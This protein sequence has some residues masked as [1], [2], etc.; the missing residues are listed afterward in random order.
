MGEPAPRHAVLIFYANETSQAAAHSENY[1]K[2]LAVLR[3]AGGAQAE[4]A[5][6]S[7]VRDAERFPALVQRD[8]G[9][10]L[11]AAQRWKFDAA[12][13]TNEMAFAG[14]YLLY[15]AATDKIEQVSLPEIPPT[16]SVILATSP[17]ARPD[18][19]RSA[20]TAVAAQY[21]RNSLDAVLITDTHGSG[22]M[23]LIPRVNADLS[24]PDAERQMQ[25]LLE[26]D[27][28]GVPP[29]WAE[30]PGT[31]KLAY[32]QTISDV[33]A[34]YG[35]R[36]PLAFREACDSGLRTWREFAMLPD[37]VGSVAHSAMGVLDSA[38]ISYARIF[39]DF[40]PGGDWQSVL[41]A[42][43]RGDG[44][45]VNGR[46]TI[47]LWVALIGL[48]SVPPILFFVPLGAWLIWYLAGVAV[49]RRRAVLAS[50]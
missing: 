37:S 30:L 23:A 9:D 4:Q 50:R 8:I 41:A 6:A 5:S 3:R 44:V 48:G 13:F 35:V 42:G 18:V 11:A 17:L 28:N 34:A 16:T 29:E 36:F 46:W 43:L 2:V 32:W 31:G 45:H 21:P 39:A 1:A 22:E 15:R 47:W 14:R 27:D 49:R 40:R 26:S 38:D 12:V 24:R 19:F 20:L 33:S 7:I 10:L 25:Q